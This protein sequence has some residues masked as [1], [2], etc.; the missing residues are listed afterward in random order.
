MKNALPGSSQNRGAKAELDR[1]AQEGVKRDIFQVM[2][3][4]AW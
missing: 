2:P 1:T 3:E 4:L